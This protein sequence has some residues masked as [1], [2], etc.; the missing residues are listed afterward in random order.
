MPDKKFTRRDFVGRTTAAAA[1]ALV[2]TTLPILYETSEKANCENHFPHSSCD[3][4]IREV[5]RLPVEEPY[6]YHKYLSTAP[7]H[8]HRRDRGARRERNEMY[9]PD[10]GW[11]IT[12]NPE[13]MDV[14]KQAVYD[15]QDYLITSHDVKVSVKENQ[16]KSWQHI[17]KSIIVGTIK[18]MPQLGIDLENEKDYV[19]QVARERIVVCGTTERGAM[20]GL[21]NLEARMNLREAPFLPLKLNS[22]RRSL[23]DTRMVFSWMGWMEFPDQLLSRLVHDGFDG[24][25]ASAYA[26]PNGDVTTAETSTEF[27]ARLLFRI[28][29]QDPAQV[30]DLI[31]RAS[32]F[33]IK[34]YAPV[35][36]Q[37]LG[38]P[39]SESGLRTL[40]RNI[41]NEFPEIRGYILLTEGFWY[42]TWGGGHG[43]S[44]AY[45][46]E[47]AVKWS[48]AVGIVEEECHRIN[49]SIEILPWE[50]NIDFRPENVDVKRFFIRQLPQE[51]IP[52]LTFENGKRFEIDGM[53][54]Y[55]RDY[56]LS[57]TGPAEVTAGQI[58]E[59]ESR[60]MKVYSKV[61]TFATWQFGT[62]PYLP[63]PRQWLNRYDALEKSG[64]KGTLESWS[65]GYKPNFICELRAWTCWSD[66]LSGDELLRLTA[67]R[68]FG[69]AGADKAIAAWDCFS[70]AIRLVPDTGP[71]MGNNN[72]AGNPI[73][74]DVPPLRTCTYYHS[75]TDFDKWRGYFGGQLNPYW[76]FTVSRMVFYPDFTNTTNKAEEYARLAT[77]VEADEKTRIL[78]VFLKY[79]NLAA[80]K[81][82][83]G[84]KLYREA[85]LSGPPAKRQD[86]VREVIIAEQ[87]TRM[88]RSNC[89][90]L[91]F[92]DLRLKLCAEKGSDKRS[93]ILNRMESILQD[94]ISRTEL[95]LL[96][97]TRD[98]RLGFQFEQ[99]YVFTPY[100]LKEKL[101][102]LNK[103]LNKLLHEAGGKPDIKSRLNS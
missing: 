13:S 26:N 72:S 19:V 44:R 8:I 43:A 42:G 4:F 82:E 15:F 61:D 10:E 5:E 57:Q 59:A 87:M 60:G 48:Q 92:E 3:E 103:T 12:W 33:G 62:M 28:R 37:Y 58:N 67:Q 34:V 21:Y 51:T 89:A 85:A 70:Q 38:T 96:A 97:V 65:S 68:I 69:R 74:F 23:Y 1:S 53:K 81:M 71:N 2:S 24:I 76:P 36:Y 77:G 9:V 78:P 45:L 20:F 56:S 100:S 16:L 54:G 79:L 98:S 7:V 84:L 55:L 80:G 50:Y 39:E 90:I 14:L 41:V 83:E 35:I 32:R 30:H 17:R 29:R 6:A 66:S 22:V 99:D 46:E 91:E 93:E 31:R 102:L 64:I 75:W 101:A 95:T 11:S 27:Y 86:A 52:L 73:F 88:M 47:W 94:E 25:Y 18:Q 49:P 63:C 40:V